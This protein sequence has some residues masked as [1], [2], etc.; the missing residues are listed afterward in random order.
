M[1]PP[2]TLFWISMNQSITHGESDHKGAEC[3]KVGSPHAMAYSSVGPVAG[4]GGGKLP[5][6]VC[7]WPHEPSWLH[8][9][10]KSWLST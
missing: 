8:V 10:G 5:S 1:D 2:P 7:F 6:I 4:Q 3:E 9:E